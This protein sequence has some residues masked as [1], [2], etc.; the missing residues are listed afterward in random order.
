[1][2]LAYLLLGSILFGGSSNSTYIID[3]KKT[4]YYNGLPN[5]DNKFL[6]KGSI[7][8]N[9]KVFSIKYHDAI[10]NNIIVKDYFTPPS[11]FS[12]KATN[13]K[14]NDKLININSNTIINF[15]FHDLLFES[16]INNK[17]M[18]NNE[19]F[20]NINQRVYDLTLYKEQL[21]CNNTFVYCVADNRLVNNAFNAIMITDDEYYV[22]QY[23]HEYYK[24]NLTTRGYTT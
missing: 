17:I 19:I 23:Y 2:V 18:Q 8:A 7:H 13:I 4:A 1:M 12:F 10:F 24:K 9:K 20:D 11:K 22:E 15:K 14:I 3:I 16:Q 6:M 21:I 5:K